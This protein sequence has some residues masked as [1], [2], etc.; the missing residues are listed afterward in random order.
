L[1][2]LLVVAVAFQFMAPPPVL[3]TVMLCEAG[4]RC[5]T[6]LLNVR[7]PGVTLISGVVDCP[8]VYV[9]ATVCVPITEEKTTVP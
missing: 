2:P 5:P 9:T 6:T 7:A 1:P 3:P 4:L 8:I